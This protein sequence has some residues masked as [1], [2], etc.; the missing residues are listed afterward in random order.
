MGSYKMW[1]TEYGAKLRKCVSYRRD[2]GF[3]WSSGSIGSP[4][5]PYQKDAALCKLDTPIYVDDSKVDF[6]LNAQS[7]YP[8]TGTDVVAVGFGTLWSG[9]SQP[10]IIQHV[11][12]K[13][14]SNSYCAS[15]PSSIYNSNTIGPGIICACKF[16]AIAFVSGISSTLV[17]SKSHFL[18]ATITSCQWGRKGCLSRRFWWPSCPKSKR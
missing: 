13:V 9:G 5:A 8:S 15:A 6:R 18:F 16:T 1:S 3:E 14:N 12:V 10:S 7:N 2:P 17:A 4:N 11:T